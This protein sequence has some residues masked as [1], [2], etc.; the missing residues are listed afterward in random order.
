M[1]SG[2]Y[3]VESVAKILGVH[4]RT[5]LR[6]IN[7][8]KLKATK[9]GRQWRIKRTDLDELIGE[10][11]PHGEI[12]TSLV[13]DIPL[14]SEDDYSR[15]HNTLFAAINSSDSS[16]VDLIFNRNEMSLRITAWGN[17]E[18]INNITGLLSNLIRR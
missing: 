17:L 7:S 3:D 18:L 5:V 16:R 1:S 10:D 13:V 14:E 8:G 2:V 9:V 6:F 4:N 15:I 11:K 12:K